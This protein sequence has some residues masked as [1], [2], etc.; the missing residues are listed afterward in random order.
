MVARVVRGL[1]DNGK[2]FAGFVRHSVRS[3]GL[4]ETGRGLDPPTSRRQP[5]TETTRQ[6]LGAISTAKLPLLIRPFRDRCY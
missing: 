1:P 5:W 2:V 3:A 6:H 4:G